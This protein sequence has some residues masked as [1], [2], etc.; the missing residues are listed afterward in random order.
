MCVLTGFE[1]YDNFFQL[2]TVSSIL[3]IGKHYIT[4]N[5]QTLQG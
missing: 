4:E 5:W 2:L 3:K 1:A